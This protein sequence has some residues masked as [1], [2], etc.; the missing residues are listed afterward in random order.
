MVYFEFPKHSF[1]TW[2]AAIITFLIA[3]AGEYHQSLTGGRTPS[4]QDVMLGTADAI[5]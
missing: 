3:M 1:R 4:F 2:T 5:V